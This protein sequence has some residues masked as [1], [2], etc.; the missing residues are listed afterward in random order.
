[1]LRPTFPSSSVSCWNRQ[2]GCEIITQVSSI[3]EHFHKECG[4][5]S[6]CCP[7]CSSTVLRKDIIAHL[8]SQCLNFV[9]RLRST[10][11]PGE[12]DCNELLLI[13]E[14]VRGISTAFRNASPNDAF[15]ATSLQRVAVKHGEYARHLSKTAVQAT[16]MPE[17]T[18]QALTRT[19][20]SSGAHENQI[21]DVNNCKESL[22]MELDAIERATDQL[23]S[24][25]LAEQ[26]ELKEREENAKKLQVLKADMQ[27]VVG[28]IEELTRKVHLETA[29][30][31]CAA[32]H[33]LSEVQSC[34]LLSFWGE[35]SSCEEYPLR[36]TVR[37]FENELKIPVKV[38]WCVCEW[39]VL[40]V[41]I[42]ERR[43]FKACTIITVDCRYDMRLMML[44]DSGG[45]NQLWITVFLSG[46]DGATLAVLPSHATLFFINRE[47]CAA[48]NELKL[49]H[50]DPLAYRGLFGSDILNV[51]DINSSGA[52]E[53]DVLK[54]C[55]TFSY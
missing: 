28:L 54:M 3:A 48:R 37:L 35:K 46:A 5:H 2:N 26:Q 30:A 9:L 51:Q 15:L 8:E 36:T 45:C 49:T 50:V 17:L 13:R 33:G 44:H 7:R 6:V 14:G 19:E 52:L 42:E 41:A 21:A 25:E 11:P 53:R 24:L 43:F 38:V 23:E 10:T 32:S 34:E 27:M 29:V 47:K 4:Y 1:M 18:Q 39:S 20:R 31:E 55:I 40:S 12:K 22:R 16:Q